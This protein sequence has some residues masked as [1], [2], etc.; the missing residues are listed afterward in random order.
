[1][2]D[3]LDKQDNWG[4]LNYG[5]VHIDLIKEEV[6]SY[7]NEWLI[8]TSRQD[9]YITHEKTFMYQLCELDYMWSMVETGYRKTTNSFKTIG[10]KNQLRQIYDFLEESFNGRVVRC[11]VVNMSPNSRVRDHKDR[12]DVLYYSRRFHIPLKTNPLCF[13]TVNK[14]TVNMLEGNL[15]E[16]NNTKWHNVKNES[17]NNRIHL[18]VDIMPNDYVEN[19]RFE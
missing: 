13:F 12:S 2:K 4:I 19:I 11:E 6:S 18:I 7:Y 17:S 5:P 3:I 9:K 10:A 8:D 15:Y 1:M 16:I 14:E